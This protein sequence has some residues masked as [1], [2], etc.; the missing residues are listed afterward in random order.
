M[1]K[2][3]LIRLLSTSPKVIL[4]GFGAFLRKTKDSHAVFTPFLRSDDGFLASEVSEEYGVSLDDAKEMVEAFINHINDTITTKQHFYFEGVGTLSR[5]VNGAITFVMDLSKQIPTEATAVSE[6][7]HIP[8]IEPVPQIEPEPKVVPEPIP[9]PK[10]ETPSPRP[11]PIFP[12]QPKPNYAPQPHKVAQPQPHSEYGATV[13]PRPAAPKPLMGVPKAQF[14]PAQ[15]VV[16]RPA[17]TPRPQRPQPIT[18]QPL[19]RPQPQQRAQVSP[20][21]PKMQTK[22]DPNRQLRQSPQPTR[23]N[24]KGDMWLVIAIIAAVVV[25]G[26]MVYGILT[27]QEAEAMI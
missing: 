18:P 25:I 17:V 14:T 7:T 4:P 10:V 9:A 22:A 27:A 20:S 6:T 24:K 21:T 2:N 3:L 23:K 11:E 26:L 8:Q 12:P 19:S 15:P 1:D 13:T 5:D 16:E